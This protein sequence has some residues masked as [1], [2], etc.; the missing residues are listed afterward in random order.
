[1]D[2]GCCACPQCALCVHYSWVPQGSA[3]APGPDLHRLPKRE[4]HGLAVLWD[5]SHRKTTL[6]SPSDRF[7][8]VSPAQQS[9]PHSPHLTA[10]L[11]VL[12]PL[13]VAPVPGRSTAPVKHLLPMCSSW[14]LQ[15]CSKVQLPAQSSSPQGVHGKSQHCPKF[16]CSL[17]SGPALCRESQKG[18]MHAAFL[19]HT[20]NIQR[21]LQGGKWNNHH[22]KIA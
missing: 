12:R 14:R 3:P 9:A 13:Q 17:H 21:D 19:R 15:A 10:V 5:K 22:K 6:A 20:P 4:V 8:F 11:A 18:P 16:S 1:M 7:S 2:V